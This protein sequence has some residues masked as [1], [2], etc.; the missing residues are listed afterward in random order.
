LFRDFSRMPPPRPGEPRREGHGLGLAISAGLVEAM[1]GRIGMAP[2]PGGRGSRFWAELPLREVIP[3]AARSL[4]PREPRILVVD[5]VALNRLVVQALLEPAAYEVVLTGGGQEAIE[6]LEAEEFDLVLMDVR[7]PGMDG[8]EATRRIR[9]AEAARGDG[10][11]IPIIALTGEEMVDEVQAC[12]NAG[13]DAHLSKPTDRASLLALVRRM[14]RPVAPDS[15]P[16]RLSRA[17]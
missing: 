8:L 13:M 2:G 9:A 14:L 16:P 15:A 5:D 7:M 4:V 11:H 10:R 17:S 1:G 12:F 6:A 3:P